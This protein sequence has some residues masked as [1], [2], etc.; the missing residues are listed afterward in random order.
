MANSS[1]HWYFSID[2]SE[3]PNM[4]P[5]ALRILDEDATHADQV[6]EMF[7]GFRRHGGGFG[8]EGYIAFEV[9]KELSFVQEL[10]PIFALTTFNFIAQGI[11]FRNFLLRR[12]IFIKYGQAWDEDIIVLEVDWRYHELA[13]EQIGNPDWK[14]FFKLV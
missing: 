6:S 8:I 2:D 11:R 4:I 5:Q 10:L 3:D 13:M 12:S 14:L 1:T 7:Y 9:E